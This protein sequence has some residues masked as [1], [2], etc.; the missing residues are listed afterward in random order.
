MNRALYQVLGRS[1]VASSSQVTDIPSAKVLDLSRQCVA[2]KVRSIVNKVLI[3]LVFAKD[4]SW[5]T[6]IDLAAH[7]EEDIQTKATKDNENLVADAVL[8]GCKPPSSL[9]TKP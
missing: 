7:F 9:A 2:W 1:E 4:G 8:E 6:H 3:Y 5:S